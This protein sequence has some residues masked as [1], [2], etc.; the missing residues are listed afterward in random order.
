[1]LRMMLKMEQDT[2]PMLEEQFATAEGELSPEDQ[3][4]V[5]GNGQYATGISCSRPEA[6]GERQ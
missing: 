5:I 3:H 2:I 4:R 6:T 1:M